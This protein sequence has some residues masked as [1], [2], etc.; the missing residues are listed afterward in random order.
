[1]TCKTRNVPAR[2]AHGRAAIA[3]GAASLLL[4]G[5]VATSLA[6]AEAAAAG[7]PAAATE[8]TGPWSG[9]VR[10]GYI[11]TTGNTE[12]SNANF[13][14]GVDYQVERWTHGL[15]GSAVGA[16]QDNETT[17]EAYTLGWRS[18]RDLTERDYL[19]GRVDWLK[20]KF[21]G[22]DQQLSQSVG[23]GRR[24]IMQP[25]QTLNL[26][27]GPGAR[28]SELRNGDEE[29]E[30]IVRLGANYA[31][32]FNENARF[33]FDLGV[34]AGE[35]NT[36]TEAVAGL[37]TRLYGNLAAVLSYT[38]R[39]NTDVPD[40]TEKTDTMTSVSLEYSF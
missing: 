38:L 13:A 34:Q 40:D 8:P 5:P 15:T 30:V 3:C 18:K 31:Y 22:Y 23:Y 39:N 9:N 29:K 20:D 10:L 25:H 17:A 16:S 14:F 32:H 28:Q 33:N 1:M 19:F 11:A 37:T 24:V 7:D 4:L 2:P 12:T 35:E 21:S 36:F 6:N 27:I 26:E